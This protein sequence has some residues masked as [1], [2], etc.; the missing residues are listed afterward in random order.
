MHSPS[1]SSGDGELQFEEFKRWQAVA[2]GGEVDLSDQGAKAEQGGGN[3]EA[4]VST[5][6]DVD[7]E[8]PFLDDVF[9]QCHA[10]RPPPT[11]PAAFR[12]ALAQRVFSGPAEAAQCAEAYE[13][14]FFERF[15]CQEALLYDSNG[16]GDA[17]AAQ[18]CDV[19][20]GLVGSKAGPCMTKSLWLS[21][22]DLTDEGMR[23]IARCVAAGALPCLEQVHVHGNPQA[24]PKAREEIRSAKPGIQVHYGGMGGGRENH[25]V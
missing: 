4:V 15:P 20:T 8:P 11:S 14:F 12:D 7:A 3:A 1:P 17:E 10:T 21:R 13:S 22:N 5:A 18:L 23:T 2:D 6:A 24:S 25:S 19:L 16:W 9:S